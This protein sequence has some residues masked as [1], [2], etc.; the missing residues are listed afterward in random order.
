VLV[1]AKTPR[2]RQ[3]V[4]EEPISPNQAK[5]WKMIDVLEL[6]G[7]SS[8]PEKLTLWEGGRK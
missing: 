3:G 6:W 7:A 5:S 1:A 2:K 8:L 4:L